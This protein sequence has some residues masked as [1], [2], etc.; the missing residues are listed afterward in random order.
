MTE[1]L[2]KNRPKYEAT[3]KI[4][5]Y[6]RENNLSPNM[7]LPSERDMS[8]LWG[9][10]RTSV[11]RAI[12]RL[13]NAGVLYNKMGSGTYVAEPKILRNLQNYIP[14]KETVSQA[15]HRFTTAVLSTQII[16]SNKQIAA[17]LELR[18]GHKV[19]ALTRLR[20]IDGKPF[21]LDTS[22][23]DIERF[24]GL[25]A[26]D[27]ANQS[28]YTV[29][30]EEYHIPIAKGNEHISITYATEDEA[31]HLETTSETALFFVSGIAADAHGRPTEYAKV[32]IRPNMVRFK[33]ELTLEGGGQIG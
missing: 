31:K 26:H 23:L 24:P 8:E 22:Y 16:E 14:F 15:G 19:Y 30:A 1:T 3:E 20:S 25:D 32:V 6:I 2:Y 29:L 27:F 21:M 12:N 10:S 11:R 28:L 7:K 5:S 9:L 18:L 17:N 33:S 4:E 13:I